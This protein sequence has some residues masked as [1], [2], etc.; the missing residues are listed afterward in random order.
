MDPS[1][2]ILAAVQSRKVV[3]LPVGKE[4]VF[5]SAL[6]KALAE[7]AKDEDKA[8]CMVSTSCIAK[9]AD[10][11]AAFGGMTAAELIEDGIPTAKINSYIAHCDMLVAIERR[12]AD[13]TL[14]EWVMPPN[15]AWINV[16]G[17]NSMFTEDKIRALLDIGHRVGKDSIKSASAKWSDKV[18]LARASHVMLDGVHDRVGNIDFGSD[19][20]AKVVA[21]YEAALTRAFATKAADG[22]AADELV[23]YDSEDMDAA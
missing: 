5:K 11:S 14:P 9:I 12:I 23:D 10:V 22:L 8:R 17:F 20:F 7:A 19:V 15:V 4:Y 6:K 21:E 2:A 18:P 1:L 16:K 13:G 3:R